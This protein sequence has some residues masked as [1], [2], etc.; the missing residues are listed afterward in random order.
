ADVAIFYLNEHEDAEETK[1]LVELEGKKCILLDGDIGSMTFC[2]AAVTKVMDY[3][4]KIDIL[5]NNAAEQ[6]PQDNFLDI[7]H[8]QLEKT[9]RTNVFG[10]FYMTKAVLPHLKEGSSII[11]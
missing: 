1:R 8:E 6:H 4:G 10:A 9:F 3:F 2:E 5:I 11:N 7:S